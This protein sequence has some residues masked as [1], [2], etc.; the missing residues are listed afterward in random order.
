MQSL[1]KT[2][3]RP[4]RLWFDPQKVATRAPTHYLY[5]L[6]GDTY[7]FVVHLG[8]PYSFAANRAQG[9]NQIEISNNPIEHEG[10]WKYE[11]LRSD[12]MFRKSADALPNR[13]A[14]LNRQ[15]SKNR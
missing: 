10:F 6:E 12:P 2:L 3:E 11:D 13:N 8:L 9:F 5:V 7:F 14:W 1:K 4:V 15:E